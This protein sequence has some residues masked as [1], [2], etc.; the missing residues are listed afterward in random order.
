MRYLTTEAKSALNPTGGFLEGGYTH[1]FNPA[2]GC[3]FAAGFCGSFCYARGFAERLAGPGTWGKSVILKQNAAQV[4]ER[5]LQRAGRRSPDHP[6]FVEHL[7]VFSAS[8]TD[9]CA[10][11]TLE[12]YRD[13]L[14]V[15][16]RHPIRRWVLQTRSPAV[17]DLRTEIEAL[18]ERCVIS[19]SLETD[20]EE[21]WRTGPP[22]APGIGARKRAFEALGTWSVRRHLAVSPCLPLRDTNAFADWID[23]F[24]TEATVDTFLTGDGSQ[25]KRTASS[26]LPGILEEQGIDWRDERHARELHAALVERMGERAGWSAQGFGRLG[27]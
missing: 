18:G 9:P 1:S 11:P 14:R 21:L 4:L 5:E 13:C 24:A 19:F 15:V 12:L 26:L 27:L 20:D 25:G 2:I 7:S 17:V 10:G 8:T 16:A 22:G 3:T 23:E 6:H